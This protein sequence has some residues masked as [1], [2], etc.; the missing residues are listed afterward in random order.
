MTA[1]MPAGQ[2]KGASMLS[3][4][5]L[6]KGMLLLGASPLLWQDGR[7]VLAQEDADADAILDGTAPVEAEA[8]AALAKERTALAAAWLKEAQRPT[9]VFYYIYDPVKDEYE[10]EQYNDVRHAG[11][12]YAL[13]QAYGLLGDEAVLATAEGAGGY[14]QKNT[15]P[16][17]SA[18]E[19]Y[20]DV[21]NGDTSLGGQALA[22]VALVE[23]RRVTGKTDADELIH[24]MAEFLLWMEYE[25]RN[26]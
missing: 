12:T 24:E 15:V 7:R 3:R 6:T 20:L 26:G 18:G 19:A 1:S 17:V 2:L 11:T 8:L 25:D 23:R 21:Q 5:Q 9:G 13:Y 14:I 22:L 4:R 16:I 10:I